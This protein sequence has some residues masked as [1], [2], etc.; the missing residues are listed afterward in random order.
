VIETDLREAF[1]DPTETRKH[2]VAEIDTEDEGIGNW[3]FHPTG[4]VTETVLR[5]D[6]RASVIP[7]LS[8]D[9]LL[10]RRSNRLSA[11]DHR[12]P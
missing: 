6:L 8:G 11:R 1:R 7:C 3:I 2:G 12:R 4:L 5:E 9:E 10:V